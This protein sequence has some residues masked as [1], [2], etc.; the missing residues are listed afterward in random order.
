MAI[1][2][3]RLQDVKLGGESRRVRV[4]RKIALVSRLHS[5][6]QGIGSATLTQACGWDRGKGDEMGVI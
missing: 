4:G 1:P 5:D 3:P 2:P 6:Q